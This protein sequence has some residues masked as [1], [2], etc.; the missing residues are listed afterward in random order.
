MI[1]FRLRYI[2]NN[3]KRSIAVPPLNSASQNQDTTQ[4]SLNKSPKLQRLWNL[5]MFFIN[6]LKTVHF[7]QCNSDS[8][9]SPL[10]YEATSKSCELES[11]LPITANWICFDWMFLPR[12]VPFDLGSI[13]RIIIINLAPLTAI[14]CHNK[15]WTT[16]VSLFVTGS[17]KSSSLG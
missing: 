5:C 2:Q 17:G 3:K 8:S 12:L 1:N 10:D 15:R 11:T 7:H 14:Q 13:N 9:Q 16:F 4:I 6:C